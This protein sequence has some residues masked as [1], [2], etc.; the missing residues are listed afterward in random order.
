MSGGERRAAICMWWLGF[1]AAL[2]S[3]AV[4]FD[5]IKPWVA[6]PMLLGVIAMTVH[7]L[8]QRPVSR[9]RKTAKG[10]HVDRT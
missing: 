8:R 7:V 3:D 1:A 6:V 5:G 10:A 4:L 9:G 2:V